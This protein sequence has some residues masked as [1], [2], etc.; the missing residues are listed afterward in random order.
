MTDTAAPPPWGPANWRSPIG[1]NTSAIRPL[2]TPCSIAWFT[3]RTVS[4]SRANHCANCA[5]REPSDLTKPRAPEPNV[6]ALRPCCRPGWLPSECLAGFDRN[7]CLVS[8][9]IDGWLR[10]NPQAQRRNRLLMVRR[11]ALAL[12]AEDPRHE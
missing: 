5:P 8:I 11:F 2:L 3:R 7:R 1:T 4:A 9:G 10:R 12:R 6:A